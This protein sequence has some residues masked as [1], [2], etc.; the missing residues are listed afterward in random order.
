MTHLGPY[1]GLGRAHE[2]IRQW[3]QAHGHRPAGPT[4]EI[5]GH[6][7]PDWDHH[8]SRIRTDVFHLLEP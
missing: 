2:A 5:Y 1:D 7:Q 3:C 8:P 4:W 6:W